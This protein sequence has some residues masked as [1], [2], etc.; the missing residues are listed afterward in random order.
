MV[1]ST[2]ATPRARSPAC[3]M[4]LGLDACE[5]TTHAVTESR[6][7]GRP[8]PLSASAVGF[9]LIQQRGQIWTLR[10]KLLLGKHTHASLLT[11]RYPLQLV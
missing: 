7:P 6:S 4:R 10:L 2:N 9:F 5:H 11:F 3:A 1:P 8:V